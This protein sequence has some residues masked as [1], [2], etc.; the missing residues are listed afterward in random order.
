MEAFI[1][2]DGK[3][4]TSVGKNDSYEAKSDRTIDVSIPFATVSTRFV[5]IFAKNYG[6]IPDGQ[7]GAGTKAWLFVDEIEVN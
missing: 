2:S 5:K 1:S 7:A 4:F 6:L 3:N